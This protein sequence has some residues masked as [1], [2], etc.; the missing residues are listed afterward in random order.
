MVVL[1]PSVLR[2]SRRRSRVLLGVVDTV[3]A[4][5]RP[6]PS[7]TDL[8]HYDRDRLRLR[9]R[10]VGHNPPFPLAGTIAAVQADRTV[11][12]ARRDCDPHAAVPFARPELAERRA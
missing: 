6:A 11:D 4:T 2:R 8:G 1:A 9:Q 10:R 3:A 5:A 12:A 7:R